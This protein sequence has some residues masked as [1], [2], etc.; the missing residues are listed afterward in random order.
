MSEKTRLISRADN[1]SSP[2][3]V[4]DVAELANWLQW[5]AVWPHSAGLL[6][7]CKLLFHAVMQFQSKQ[8]QNFLCEGPQDP[9]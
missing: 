9:H 3:K 8:V 1:G 6:Y 2:S 4:L 7:M 5:L